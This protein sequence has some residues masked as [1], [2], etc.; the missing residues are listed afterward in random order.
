MV[1]LAWIF[2]GNVSGCCVPLRLRNLVRAANG[3]PALAP[4]D[5]GIEAGENTTTVA[6]ERVYPQSSLTFS[7]GEAGLTSASEDDLDFARG[8]LVLNVDSDER[9]NSGSYPSSANR[10]YTPAGK[11]DTSLRDEIGAQDVQVWTVHDNLG[12][13]NT[14]ADM[15]AG[16]ED[17]QQRYPDNENELQ[18]EY[19]YQ[20]GDQSGYR[21]RSLGYREDDAL[22][23]GYR[24]SDYD[25]R[26]SYTGSHGDLRSNHRDS[27]MDL[28]SLPG[29][30][31][32]QPDLNGRRPSNNSH[33]SNSQ[34]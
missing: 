1:I 3:K 5:V 27:T 29:G 31:Y 33:I 15:R 28:Q 22:R 2:I 10:F 23:S 25:L 6:T 21:D 20:N 7:P 17:I 19:D 30:R 32:H 34:W 4:P 13:A 8:E 9:V 14:E 18:S 26:K 24:S 12:Y 16:L 11:S